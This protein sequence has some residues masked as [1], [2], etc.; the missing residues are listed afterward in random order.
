MSREGSTGDTPD[1]VQSGIYRG[2][3]IAAVTFTA[4]GAV[5]GTAQF[6]FGVFILPLEED[7]FRQQF[8]AS[9]WRLMAG[10]GTESFDEAW[11][12]LQQ[13]DVDTVQLTV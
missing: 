11:A 9:F 10:L 5:L 8:D 12:G 7:V 4:L 13:P 1:P 3:P 2:W 6:A